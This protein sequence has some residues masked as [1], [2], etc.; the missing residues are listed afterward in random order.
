[1]IRP[2][3]EPVHDMWLRITVDRALNIVD[4]AAAMD[5]VPFVEH[6]GAIVP[7]YRK[8]VGLAIRPGYHN[9]LK[10]L[11]GGVR[12]CTHVTELAGAL[13]TAAFQTLAGQ[14]SQDPE[15]KPFQVDRCHAL[16][17]SGPAVARYYP[18]WHRDAKPVEETG[19]S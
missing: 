8:L 10:E 16:E 9:R 7:A 2:A 19:Q 11:L 4:A 5:A 14:V 3:G 13:A 17:G 12:G 6:C 15:R 1:G 18:K